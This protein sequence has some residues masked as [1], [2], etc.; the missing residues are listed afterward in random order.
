MPCSLACSWPNRWSGSCCC[1]VMSCDLL[2]VLLC[3]NTVD[4]KMR[5][6]QFKS[7]TAR[8]VANILQHACLVAVS[9]LRAAALGGSRCDRCSWQAYLCFKVSFSFQLCPRSFWWSICSS[10]YWLVKASHFNSTSW[11]LWDCVSTILCLVVPCSGD[12]L[13]YHNQAVFWQWAASNELPNILFAT[14]LL[15]HL[16]KCE[17]IVYLSS[18]KVSCF[19]MLTNKCLKHSKA[20][21]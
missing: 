10:Q 5:W 14:A 19:A 12:K 9:K 3:C 17:F 21:H 2:S 6:Q 8:H 16:H 4:S 20:I 1:R 18:I 13:F 11:R 15:Y 7:G